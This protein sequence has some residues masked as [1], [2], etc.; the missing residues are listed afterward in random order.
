MDNIITTMLPILGWTFFVLAIVAGLVL[1]MVGLF[2]NWI[3][4]GAVG[5]VWVVT[6][7]EHFGLPVLAVLAVLAVVG[8]VIET[9]AAG[10]GAAKFGGGKGA[11][12]PTVIG[13]LLGAMVGTAWLFVLGTLIGACVGAF[14]GAALYEYI[15][16]ERHVHYAVWVG[17]GGALGKVAGLFAKLFIGFA[18][19]IIAWLAY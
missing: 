8:E 2:G 5:V 6:G 19:V 18:M 1:D 14:I 13:C 11:T 7:F 15:V 17:L 10:Y 12:V 16:R 9:A 4:L 3:I